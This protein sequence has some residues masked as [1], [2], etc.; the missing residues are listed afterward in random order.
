MPRHIQTPPQA[1][2]L[3]RQLYN[4][5][6]RA[7][8]LNDLTKSREG[9]PGLA[10]VLWHSAGIMTVLLHEVVSV[11]PYMSDPSQLT[12]EVSTRCCNALAL[13][14]LVATHP[15]TRMPFMHANFPLFLY[16]FLNTQHNERSFEY[17]RLTSLGVV[18]ALVKVDDPNIISFLLT[19]EIIPLCLHIM[20]TGTEW[21]Q[22]VATFII[23][24]ILADDAGLN[25]MCASA[26]RFY[27]VAN[28]LLKMVD[29][30]PQAAAQSSRLLMRIVR[31]YRRLADNP[32]AAE[33]FRANHVPH[34][35]APAG[36][37]KLAQALESDRNIRPIID[38]FMSIIHNSPRSMQRR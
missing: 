37:H 36:I 23:Q 22:T 38:D 11:Y 10:L 12:S 26:D 25:Y 21:S 5:A 7:Q 28:V 18:G 30:F 31:C 13:M 29:A 34:T 19:T 33:A 27:F 4:P 3:V 8:A 32:R 24:K 35:F 1:L 6:T 9:I 20:E 2:E 16:P 17:L 14:Q 15:E